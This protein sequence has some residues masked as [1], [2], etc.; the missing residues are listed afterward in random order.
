MP[1][2]RRRGKACGT[3]SAIPRVMNVI[4]RTVGRVLLILLGLLV[5]VFALIGV[6]SQTRGTPVHSVQGVTGNDHL[7]AVGDSLFARSM[8]LHTATM[9]LPGNQVELVNNGSVYPRLW[10]DL[11]SAHQT[12]TVQMYFSMPGKVADSMSAVLRERARAGVRV[13]ML[14]DAFGSGP[15][16]DQE[17]YLDSLRAAGV[18]LAQLRPLR[19]RS[20]QKASQRSHA[21]VV[22]VDGRIG[23]TGG[24]GLADYWL[25]DGHHDE[26]WREGNVRMMGPVVAQ[27][28]AAFAAGWA[29]ATGELLTGAL[30]F[31][32]A[33]F[34]GPGTASAGLMHAMPT[35]GSTPAERFYA[36]T[37]AGARRTLYITNSYFVPDDDL[38][39]QLIAAARRGVD[40]RVL[41]VSEKTDVKTT[42]WA[43]RR[44][45]EELLSGGVKI[46]EY[47]PTMMHAKTLVADGLW[48][49][50]G[51]MNFDNR[52]IAFNNET[53]L[54]ALDASLGRMMD[55]VFLD[56]LRFSREMKLE[57]FRRRSWWR[58]PVEFGASLLARLL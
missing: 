43:G 7:P 50:V 33:T 2:W 22:V 45:Y 39:R 19:W 36:L 9:Q 12:I 30:F 35:L 41:T 40:V 24:F 28:Q 32:A 27:L 3:Y 4:K 26:Q 11:R 34:N 31:P 29:E 57:E 58:R 55:S 20:L 18:E 37:I 38:R 14:L 42:W 47:A 44:F 5:L 23:Y 17:G 53:N 51:S 13:L 52:S 49:S 54:L 46:Y 15:L 6:L 1:L 8:E 21:R 56:D 16:I 25:G 48:T 10:A